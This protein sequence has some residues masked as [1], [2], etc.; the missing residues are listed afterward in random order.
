[1]LSRYSVHTLPTSG[2][3]GCSRPK[4]HHRVTSAHWGWLHGTDWIHTCTSWHYK[5]HTRWIPAVQQSKHINLYVTSITTSLDTSTNQNSMSMRSYWTA[6]SGGELALLECIEIE[7]AGTHVSIVCTHAIGEGLC[8]GLTS[9]WY[10]W[11]CLLN[12]WL[13]C[14]CRSRVTIGKHRVHNSVGKSTSSAQCS[15]CKT[16]NWLAPKRSQQTLAEP[17][18]KSNQCSRLN[19]RLTDIGERKVAMAFRGRLEAPMAQLTWLDPE[20]RICSPIRTQSKRAPRALKFSNCERDKMTPVL[21]DHEYSR[22]GHSALSIH[23]LLTL[24]GEANTQIR[25]GRT[26]TSHHEDTC[27]LAPQTTKQNQSFSQRVERP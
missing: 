17:A 5:T 18:T 12:S 15:I 19:D 23:F 26:R 16:W 10:L 3:C 13:R 7:L 22:G 27:L 1:M 25:C 20:S 21:L 9:T 24:S 14:R 11:Q 6:C 2:V 4:E 8:L